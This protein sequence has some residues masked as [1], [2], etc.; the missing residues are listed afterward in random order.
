MLL[1]LGQLNISLYLDLL[2]KLWD[3]QILFNLNIFCFYLPYKLI[4][5][6]VPWLNTCLKTTELELLPLVVK[7]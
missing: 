1:F 6:G 2:R 3:P 5:Q 4:S 7:H